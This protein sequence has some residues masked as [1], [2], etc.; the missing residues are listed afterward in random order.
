MRPT[1]FLR[2]SI[3]SFQE[4][5]PLGQ[6][7]AA[8]PRPPSQRAPGPPERIPRPRRVGGGPVTSQLLSGV[9]R[10]QP[11]PLHFPAPPP[12]PLHTPLTA[13]F[14]PAGKPEQALSAPSPG[15]RVRRGAACGGTSWP[16]LHTR[17]LGPGRKDPCPALWAPP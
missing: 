4:N 10:Q 1:S 12:A 3:P 7:R 13:P 8:V 11:L 5:V 2:G 15:R 16:A 17:H 9:A 6:L 14:L